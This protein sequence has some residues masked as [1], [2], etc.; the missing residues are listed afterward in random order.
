[1]IHEVQNNMKRILLN[2][3]PHDISL[4][5]LRDEICRVYQAV[6]DG[7]FVITFQREKFQKT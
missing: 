6:N 4:A 3:R 2:K 5:P 7:H 1:M